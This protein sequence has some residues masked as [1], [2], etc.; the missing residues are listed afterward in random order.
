M[1]QSEAVALITGASRGIGRATVLELHARRYRVVAVARSESAL[2]DLVR[3]RAGMLALPADVTDVDQVDR[4]VSRTVDHFGRL[5]A[6][7]HCAGLAPQVSVEQ[8]SPAQWREVIDT[9]LSAAFYL[10]R[11]SWPVFRRQNSGVIVNLSSL[12]ARDPFPG[13]AAYAS[14][15]AGLHLLGLVMAREGQAIGVRVHTLALGAVETEM[16]RAIMTEA[17][18]GRDKTLDPAD[19]ARTIAACVTGELRYTSGEVIYLHKTV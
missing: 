18:F 17:R 16:F 8:M 2:N 10:A 6:V 11:A 3:E 5:D 9:N 14:A 12:A 13:F 1:A 19:V 7:I 15:K 4:I